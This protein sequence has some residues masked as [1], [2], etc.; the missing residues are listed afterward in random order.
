MSAVFTPTRMRITTQRYQQM[1]ERGVL[2]RCLAEPLLLTH[3]QTRIT[4]RIRPT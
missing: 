3:G 4:L 2:T 1:V